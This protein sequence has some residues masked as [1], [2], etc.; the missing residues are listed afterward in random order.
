M[1]CT[2][3]GVGISERLGTR[4]IPY[5]NTHT[6]AHAHTVTYPL[7]YSLPHCLTCTHMH[8]NAHEYRWAHTNSV[9]QIQAHQRSCGLSSV[10]VALMSQD[11]DGERG[12]VDHE[13]CVDATEGG[14]GGVVGVREEG[15]DKW[16]MCPHIAMRINDLCRYI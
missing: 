12:E 9:E 10:R 5:S 6:H 4:L 11:K 14:G 15:S 1:R 8:Q 3:V 16:E 2:Q 13:L 7:T